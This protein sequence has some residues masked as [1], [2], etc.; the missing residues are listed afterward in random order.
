MLEHGDVNRYEEG[1]WVGRGRNKSRRMFV[2]SL[3]ECAVCRIWKGVVTSNAGVPKI[4]RCLVRT[5]GGCHP[6]TLEATTRS[7]RSS[8]SLSPLHHLRSLYFPILPQASP[9]DSLV[10][11]VKDGVVAA[12]ERPVSDRSGQRYSSRGCKERKHCRTYF[13]P[14]CNSRAEGSF[15]RQGS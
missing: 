13:R 7:F 11:V 15:C 4:R 3:R 14:G 12:R 1:K 8:S 5:L 6:L 2:F 9:S 10:A